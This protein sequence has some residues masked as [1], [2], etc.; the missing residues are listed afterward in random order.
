MKRLTCILAIVLAV[1]AVATTRVTADSDARSVTGAA[2]ATFAAGAALGAVALN[3]VEIGT[4]VFIEA[5]GSASGTFH[6][7]LQGISLG[8]AIELTVEG[9]VSE[10]SIGP[11]G[12]ATFGGTA[13]IDF[14]D[15]TAP[16]PSIPFRVT[17]GA[18]GVVLTIES[19]TLPAAALSA[20]GVTID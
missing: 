1:A 5:D 12:R 14:G 13:S 18:D 10:G 17:A 20:G 4:G 3:G 15:G 16:L 2:K 9:K 19:T 7:T 11:D 6:A 8:S